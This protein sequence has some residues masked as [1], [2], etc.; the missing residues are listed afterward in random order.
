MYLSQKYPKLY[1]MPEG[2]T[3]YYE[4]LSLGLPGACLLGL[5]FSTEDGGSMLL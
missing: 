3:G 2:S 1:Y 4:G 5:L